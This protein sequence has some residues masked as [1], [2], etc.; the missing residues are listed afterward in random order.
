MRL[1]HSGF[2][3]ATI[4]RTRADGAVAEG[5]PSQRRTSPRGEAPSGDSEGSGDGLA[6]YAE[7]P[8]RRDDHLNGSASV[9]S[10]RALTMVPRRADRRVQT[11][12]CALPVTRRSQSR[13]LSAT[14]DNSNSRVYP[15]CTYCFAKLTSRQRLPGLIGRR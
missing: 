5:W 8:R 13:R 12:A 2:V 15:V 9:C 11:A 3:T 7:V 1:L 4:R 10:C 6:I 14:A